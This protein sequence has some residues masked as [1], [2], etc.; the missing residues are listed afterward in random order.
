VAIVSLIVTGWWGIHLLTLGLF[1]ALPLFGLS[2]V[3][4]LIAGY[5]LPAKTA[6]GSNFAW[7]VRGLRR[8]IQYGAWR[9]K[10]KEKNLFFEEVLPFAIA[11][12]VVDK[13]AKDMKDLNVP[14]PTYI[15]SSGMGSWATSSFINSFSAEAA[16]SLSYNPSS[17]S[18]SSGSSFSGGGSSGGGGGGGGGGSW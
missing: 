15:P 2:A 8:S 6:T 14:E 16:S 3:V 9:E 10:L 4:A 1:W 13:L 11:L 5:N 18:W 17:S 12:G 7:Q